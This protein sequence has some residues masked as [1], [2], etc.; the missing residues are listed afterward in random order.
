[1]LQV[2]GLGDPEWFGPDVS[3][4]PDPVVPLIDEIELGMDPTL[5]DPPSVGVF[6]VEDP[7]PML[8]TESADA[9]LLVAGDAH[10]LVSAAG[11][12]LVVLLK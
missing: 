2:S 1:M 4:A 9:P 7:R 8:R 5:P 10:G 12:N 6:P 11:A 3:D